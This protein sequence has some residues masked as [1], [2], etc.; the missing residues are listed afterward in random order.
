MEKRII[1]IKKRVAMYDI[2]W[3]SGILNFDFFEKMK[4]DEF[5]FVEKNRKWKNE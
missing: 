2:K 4:N 1:Y 5:V 3:L